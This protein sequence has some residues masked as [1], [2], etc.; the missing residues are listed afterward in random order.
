MN[1]PKYKES[2]TRRLERLGLGKPHIAWS[3]MWGEWLA[4]TEGEC[5]SHLEAVDF[6]SAQD[7]R[8]TPRSSK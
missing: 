8:W 2:P 1:T 6:C 7:K 3:K 5:E 4:H